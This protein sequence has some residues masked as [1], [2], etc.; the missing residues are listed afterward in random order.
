MPHDVG[1][2][3]AIAFVAGHDDQGWIDALAAAMPH[4]HIIHNQD[5]RDEEAATVQIAIVANPTPEQLLRYTGLRWV[6]S[7]WAGVERVLPMVAAQKIPLVRLIDPMLA[8]TMGEAVLAWTLFLHRDMPAYAAQQRQR[9]WQ[10]RPY[11]PPGE[12]TIGLLGLGEMGSAAAAR[13]LAAGYRVCGWSQSVKKIEGV[14]AHTGEDGLRQVLQQADIVVVLLPLTPQTHT[15]LNAE[16]LALLK[17]GAAL[18]NFARGA[19]MDTDALVVTLDAGAL[20]HA[21]L[22]VF[23]AEPLPP[24]SALWHHPKITVLP[25]VSAPTDHTSAARIVAANVARYRAD[26]V[27]PPTVDV[28]RGY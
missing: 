18:V 24:E 14:D 28:M 19:V 11:R 26:G 4:E 8:H 20:S 17:R 1:A 6:H 25:H 7:V 12:V 13:L 21:V 22:D 16:R 3:R 2:K 10:P 15:L 27:L 23:A 9:V 5:L